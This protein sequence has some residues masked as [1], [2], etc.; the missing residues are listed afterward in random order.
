MYASWKPDFSQILAWKTAIESQGEDNALSLQGPPPQYPTASP[1]PWTG[2]DRCRAGWG[3]IV[4]LLSDDIKSHNIHGFGDVRNG[5]QFIFHWNQSQRLCKCVLNPGSNVKGKPNPMLKS[6]FGLGSLHCLKANQ[7]LSKIMMQARKK[8]T[9]SHMNPQVYS[10]VYI[11][12]NSN[13]NSKVE[14]WL[15]TSLWIVW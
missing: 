8:W 12:C 14:A 7:I 13:L 1:P 11:L 6:W 3:P 2:E 10:R 4:G 9:L 5:H 15:L